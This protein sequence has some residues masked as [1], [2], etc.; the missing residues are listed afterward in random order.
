MTCMFRHLLPVH[1]SYMD[2]FCLKYFDY[3]SVHLKKD[4]PTFLHRKS[5]FYSE[6]KGWQQLTF[7]SY[8]L[9]ANR[10]FTDGIP[11]QG[12]K[13]GHRIYTIDLINKWQLSLPPH[14]TLGWH[15]TWLWLTAWSISDIVWVPEPRH[16]EALQLHFTLLEAWANM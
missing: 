3:L 13:H 1:K 2:F 4:S 10:H 12:I 9:W 7:W 6:E 5:S 16:W 11:F 14:L 15:Y 8:L